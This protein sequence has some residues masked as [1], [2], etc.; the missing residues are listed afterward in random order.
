[1]DAK[2]THVGDIGK[3]LK[4]VQDDLRNLRSNLSF[5]GEADSSAK[6]ANLQ[7]VIDRAEADLRAKAD[8]VLTTALADEFTSL[9]AIRREHKM[10]Q[11]SGPGS[12]VLRPQSAHRFEK[13]STVR[14]TMDRQRRSE[15]VSKPTSQSARAFLEERFGVTAPAAPKQRVAVR[16]RGAIVKHRTASNAGGL[17]KL[18]R[19]DPHAAPPPITGKDVERGIYDLVNRGLIPGHVDLTPAFIQ[20][21]APVLC[22]QVSLHPWEDQYVRQE[23]MACGAFPMSNIKMD[24]ISRADL[25]ATQERN[26]LRDAETL[27][28]ESAPGPT[29]KTQTL[30]PPVGPRPLPLEETE[31]PAGSPIAVDDP[32]GY[33][34]LLDTFSLHQFII[35]RGETLHSTPEFQSFKRKFG[36]VWGRITD[37]IGLLERLLSRFVVPIAYIDGNRVVHLSEDDYRVPSIDDLLSCIVNVDQVLSVVQ[38]PGRRFKGSN[39]RENATLALQSC[40]RGHVVRK[41]CVA[42]RKLNLAAAVI[43]M[44]WRTELFKRETKERIKQRA[45]DDQERFRQLQLDLCGRWDTL[46]NK[47]RV[48]VHVPALSREEAQRV[49]IQD[50]V[51]RQNGQLA[52]LTWIADP[53]VEVIYVSPFPLSP[54]V[55]QYY[56]KLLQIGSSSGAEERYK[57]VH[58]ENHSRF[59]AHMSLASVLRHSPRCLRRIRNF[60]RGKDAYIIPGV[61]GPDDVHVCLSLNLPMLAPDPMVAAVYGSKSGAKRVFAAAEVNA[62]PS[63]FDLYDMDEVAASLSSLI[64]Q[65]IDITKWLIKID[66]EFGGRGHALFDATA[67]PFHASM[68]KERSRDLAMW[69][70]PGKQEL[71][72]KRIM[73]EVLKV[74]PTKCKIMRPDLFPDWA[75]FQETFCRVGCVIEAVPA[76]IRG[77][78]SA[79]VLVEPNGKVSLHSAHDQLWSPGY[80]YIGSVFPQTSAH[81]EA[82]Q[83][84]ALA[85]GSA[86]WDKHMFGHFSVDFVSFAD[87]QGLPRLWAVDLNI[88]VHDMVT[89]FELFNFLVGGEYDVRDGH[90]YA[91]EED[92][93]APLSTPTPS[94]SDS[95]SVFQLPA[96][97]RSS[98]LRRYC[99]TTDY[100]YHSNLASVQYN[101]FFNLCRLKGVHF[102]L[103]ERVGTAFVL[104]D[105]F[106]AGTLGLLT[107][108]KQPVSAFKSMLEALDFIQLQLG[109]NKGHSERFLPA[110]TFKDA[111][112]EVKK[113]L[114][115]RSQEESKKDVPPAKGKGKPN[116]ARMT[117]F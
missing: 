102:D 86:C 24:L 90:Y 20:A 91:V 53:S 81:H 77:S 72:V 33:N 19:I 57:I 83:G 109:I 27:R 68:A 42:D 116:E 60:L 61:V 74:L 93:T 56:G 88:G 40:W 66:D 89:S 115:H 70:D 37:V 112:V 13:R 52:R 35:R 94:L 3:I 43:Q 45:L 79:C 103:Q 50:F 46:K 34:E 6:I 76:D 2:T 16:Q 67:L 100:L 31:P 41:Q 14:E 64:F 97:G 62:P 63:A 58:P 95:V 7:S 21:P 30:E 106:A 111:V 96:D 39:G 55:L 82:L 29:L 23:P 12:V 87:E 17:P 44:F 78:P 10:A 15:M 113:Q 101:V 18:N 51:V 11:P 25:P 108:A 75:S 49:S 85:V 9:P 5:G 4:S 84:A 47:K 38:V 22:G 71:A 28:V 8:A 99:V 104:V 32:R 114:E 98:S 110:G 107:V 69:F 80:R 48:V 36:P 73:Q 105:S 54:D 59:P 65:H 1:M 26:R 92:D 117:P